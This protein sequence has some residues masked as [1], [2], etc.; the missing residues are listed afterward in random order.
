MSS[1]VKKCRKCRRPTTEYSITAT[2][3]CNCC[4]Q[5]D[6][7]EY[8]MK[9]LQEIKDYLSEGTPFD[10]P[11]SY[12]KWAKRK[13]VEHTFE[14]EDPLK[15]GLGDD[16]YLFK[17]PKSVCRSSDTFVLLGKTER[18]WWRRHATLY[19]DHSYSEGKDRTTHRLTFHSGMF[20]HE[21]KRECFYHTRDEAVAQGVWEASRPYMR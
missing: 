7:I 2:T 3:L 11:K 9:R 10:A 5:I 18:G 20:S 21:F 14:D 4:D 19:L 8:A 13:H 15:K 17:V 1:E 6:R 16:V 12:A